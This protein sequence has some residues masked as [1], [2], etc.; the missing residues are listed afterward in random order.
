MKFCCEGPSEDVPFFGDKVYVL[1]LSMWKFTVVESALGTITLIMYVCRCDFSFGHLLLMNVYVPYE[2]DDD[3]KVE[4]LNTL[5]VIDNIL[6]ANASCQ[7]VLGGDFNVDF[8]RASGDSS[9]LKDFYVRM[10]LYH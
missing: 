7:V 3:S 2:K 6:V 9:V 10:K 4:F 5:S 1:V 8:C